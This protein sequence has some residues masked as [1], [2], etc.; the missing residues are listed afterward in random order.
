[1]SERY[2]ILNSYLDS[3]V[4]KILV[5]DNICK[6]LN[7]TTNGNILSMPNLTQ[8]EKLELIDSNIFV[9]KRVP[10]IQKDAK[11]LLMLRVSEIEYTQKNDSLINNVQLNIYIICANSI[12][13]TENGARDLCLVTALDEVFK[14]VDAGEIGIGEVLRLRTSDLVDLGTEYQGYVV[15]YLIT[16]FNNYLRR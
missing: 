1:M 3:F 15:T 13:N 16:D 12:I 6:L 2:G 14:N 11:P 5:N 4:S 7:Y 8:A 9:N 10:I